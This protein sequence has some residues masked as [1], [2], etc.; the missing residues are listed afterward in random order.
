[1]VEAGVILF[2]LGSCLSQTQLPPVAMELREWERDVPAQPEGPESGVTLNL[3]AHGRYSFPF[4]P[5]DRNAFVY[6][7]GTVVVDHSVSWAD[8]FHAGWGFDIE[9]DLYFTGRGLA[10]APRTDMSAGLALLF[11]RSDFDGARLSDS[12]GGEID[13]GNLNTTGLLL[14]G[15]VLQP[16]GH[17]AYTKGVLAVGAVRYSSVNATFTGPGPTQFSDEVFHSTWTIASDLRASI[18]YRFGSLG[19]SF[20]IGLRIQAPPSEGTRVSINSGAFWVFDLNLGLD[21]GF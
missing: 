11:E 4:G 10:S 8:L 21:V 20:G 18:G 3:A 5:A 2:L 15:V 1:M 19:I 7:G 14:G 12:A 17:G 16:L 9:L 13:L 6:G